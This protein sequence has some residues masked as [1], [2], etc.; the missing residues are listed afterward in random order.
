MFDIALSGAEKSRCVW[1]YVFVSV[2]KFL[3]LVFS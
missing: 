2:S 3:I 1:A